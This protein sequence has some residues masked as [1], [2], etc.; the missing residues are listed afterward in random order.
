MTSR[1]SLSPDDS[2]G[3]GGRR[4]CIRPGAK[5]SGDE[6]GVLEV[7]GE[8]EERGVELELETEETVD[9]E[10]MREFVRNREGVVR[11][12]DLWNEFF[13]E[14]VMISLQE[15]DPPAYVRELRRRGLEPLTEQELGAAAPLIEEELGAATGGRGAVVPDGESTEGRGVRVPT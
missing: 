4:D 1:L 8:Q 9:P 5:H 3:L 12:S 15:R 14:F 10:A 13:E 7:E 11:G 6:R 2:R